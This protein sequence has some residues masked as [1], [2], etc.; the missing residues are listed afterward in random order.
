MYASV[1]CR[2]ECV[3]L[4]EKDGDLETHTDSMDS[5][6]DNEEVKC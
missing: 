4:V 5:R 1:A 6:G 2:V 3:E